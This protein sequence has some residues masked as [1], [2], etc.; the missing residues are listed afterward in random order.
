MHVQVYSCARGRAH[1]SEFFSQLR[2]TNIEQRIS[3]PDCIIQ[4][5]WGKVLG[6]SQRSF[7][8]SSG[9]IYYILMK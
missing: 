9:E 4:W 6:C 8:R 1:L 7:Q 5:L 2:L 3:G